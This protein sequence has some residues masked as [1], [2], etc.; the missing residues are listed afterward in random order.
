MIMT[1][2]LGLMALFMMGSIFTPKADAI[3][4]PEGLK[5]R[6]IVS[7]V[8][9]HYKVHG[10]QTTLDKLN[11]GWTHNGEYYAFVIRFSDGMIVAHA[12]DPSLVGK[13]ASEVVNSEGRHVVREMNNVATGLGNWF[14][15]KWVNPV[16]GV[17]EDKR[18]WILRIDNYVIGSGY[19]L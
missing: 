1:K 2:K 19:Y 5:V 16:S 15:Y 11:R 8:L 9:K 7:Q 17:E 12:A 18:A 6:A 3:P 13:M 14:E 4:V 10:V